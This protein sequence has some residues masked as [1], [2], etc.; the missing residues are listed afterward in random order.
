MD[1]FRACD[2]F[3]IFSKSFQTALSPGHF[4]FFDRKSLM[5][6]RR[7]Y[8]IIKKLLNFPTCGDIISSRNKVHPFAIMERFHIVLVN[9]E[10]CKTCKE[11]SIII[12]SDETVSDYKA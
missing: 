9:H 11:T 4:N 2:F 3:K 12:T 5:V 1:G 8:Q 6:L 7:I 10:I